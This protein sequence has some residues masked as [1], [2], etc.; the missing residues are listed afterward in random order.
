LAAL[1]RDVLRIGFL[2]F[3][4][5]VLCS[6]SIHKH[7]FSRSGK[8]DTISYLLEADDFFEVGKDIS[9]IKKYINSSDTFFQYEVAKQ[10]QEARLNKDFNK[11]FRGLIALAQYYKYNYDFSEAEKLYQR[12]LDIAK[13]V[14]EL[15]FST[16]LLAEINIDQE[17]YLEA[18]EFLRQVKQRILQEEDNL[19][20]AR[21]LLKEGYC[22]TMLSNYEIAEGLYNRAYSIIE[23]NALRDLY[24][25]IFMYRGHFYYKQFDYLNALGNLF[26]GLE[27]FE[28]DTIIENYAIILDYIGQIYFHQKH[29]NKAIENFLDA[30]ALYANVNDI[31]A[32]GKMHYQLAVVFEKSNNIQLALDHLRKAQHFYKKGKFEIGKGYLYVTYASIYNTLNN[33]D[34]AAFYLQKVATLVNAENT[35]F[36]KY[37]FY[38]QKA[39]FYV[40][41]NSKDSALL[42]ADKAK[43]IG[44]TSNDI[45]I[46]IDYR[47]LLTEIYKFTGYYKKALQFQE[48]GSA[49]EDSL[50][51][52]INS[53]EIKVLQSELELSKNKVLIEHLTD[54]RNKQDETIL[55]N[56]VMLERQK[57]FIYMGVVVLLFLLLIAFLLAAFLHQK[58]KDNKKLSIRNI[59]IAQQKE[60]IEQQKQ[61]LLEAN[62]ELEKLSIIARETDNGIKI[63]NSLGRVLWVN[64]G[65]TKM[66]GYTVD[67]LQ[68][69]QNLDLLG[70]N[71]NIDIQQLVN[72]WYGD[73]QPISFESLNKT[74]KGEEIWVQTTLTPILAEDGKI[75]RMIAIDSN[76]T[77]LKKAEKEIRTKNNDITSSISYAKRIQEAMM[78]PFS[79]L[80]DHFE[81]S[82]CFYKPKSIV[83]GDFYWLSYR[84]DKIIVACADSTGH[85]VPGAF[86]SMIGISFL[87]KIVNEKG[88]V[89]PAIIL[90]R[91]RMNI[92]NHLHQKGNDAV[93]GDGMDMSIVTIDKRNN[94]L[95]YAGA[96]NP[97][98][99][100]RK[101]KLIEL[102][103]DRMPVGFFDNEDRPFSS[104][105]VSLEPNDIIYM[106]TDGYYDQ[107]GG[108][109]GSKM[110][111]HRFKA[112]IKETATKPIKEQQAFIEY[113]FNKWRGDQPQV[114]D[115]LVM[116]IGIS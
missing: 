111:G 7:V 93:A 57:V 68:N 29:F 94:Q 59:Q 73:K 86:M 108:E 26:K 15:N 17:N 116:G 39:K 23:Q 103:P 89:S 27:F 53:Y 32:I 109:C 77:E 30:K 107:F 58:R 85:G 72:V 28:Q 21:I 70:E 25:D 78:T 38:K 62:E 42:Y 81:N 9:I 98:I 13:T 82:F 5:T 18:L 60:E 99:I 106:Y 66:H 49:I 79:T 19:S 46:N 45:Q 114:D 115:V 104:S 48:R 83:S 95:E 102:K 110:K 3:M 1:I 80:T 69:K 50:F 91:M 92:I 113:E 56:E 22:Y 51:N 20:L 64:E 10:I 34:S 33:T 11:E 52:S 88:F 105:V 75:D 67:D 47:I 74:K 84:H 37:D 71:A 43:Q 41:I 2:F 44:E 90:N 112:I 4:I 40:R 14:K 96:M 16:F 87:N 97:V 24:G 55:Q 63:M 12:S 36:L 101:N 6:L 65:Y 54:E 76:I 35:S 31:R 61:H 100:A 8:V